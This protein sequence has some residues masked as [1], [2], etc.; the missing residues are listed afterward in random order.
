MLRT[1]VPVLTGCS[2]AF[3]RHA[4]GLELVYEILTILHRSCKTSGRTPA[5]G[6]ADD[7]AV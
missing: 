5:A 2:V 1:A 4:S 3:Q 7:A 6:D